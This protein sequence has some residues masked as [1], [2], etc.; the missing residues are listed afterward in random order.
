MIKCNFQK[1]LRKSLSNGEIV[2]SAAILHQRE[3]LSNGEM[4][5]SAAI[6]HQRESLS[7]GEIVTSAVILHKREETLQIINCQALEKESSR[8]YRQKFAKLQL[9]QNY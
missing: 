1:L 6:L 9:F 8:P 5:A 4:V 3:S 2:F 7:N